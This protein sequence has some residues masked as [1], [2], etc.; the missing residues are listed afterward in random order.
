MCGLG[1][2]GSSVRSTADPHMP[3]LSHTHYAYKACCAP[4]HTHTHTHTHTACA[5]CTHDVR[6][7]HAHTARSAHT[8]PMRIITC[9]IQ[10]KKPV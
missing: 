8:A 2:G 7:P 9:D 6:M 3:T 10:F 5:V 1:L 4:T